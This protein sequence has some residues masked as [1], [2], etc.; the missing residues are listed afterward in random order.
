MR[1]SVISDFGAGAADLD[2]H[3]PHVDLVD[4]VQERQRQAAAGEH[5]LLAA[6]A[7][8]DQRDVARG[9]AVEAVQESTATAMAATATAMPNSQPSTTMA[10]TSRLAKLLEK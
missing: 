6:E 10:L 5:D 1:S 4:L 9:L 3:R 8:A 7:G 2:A